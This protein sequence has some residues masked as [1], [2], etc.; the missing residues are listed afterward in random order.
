MTDPARDPVFDLQ[1]NGRAIGDYRIGE[2]EALRREL[3]D[4][5]DLTDVT[6]TRNLILVEKL[7]AHLKAR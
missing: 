5:S 4:Y 7:I 2:Q 1:I 6:Q 3:C